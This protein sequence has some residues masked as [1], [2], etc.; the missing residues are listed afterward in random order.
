[1][2]K[3]DD[4]LDISQLKNQVKL[5]VMITTVFTIT[6]LIDLMDSL[7]NIN[8]YD[9]G[10]KDTDK[11]EI[12]LDKFYT[13]EKNVQLLDIF[14]MDKNIRYIILRVKNKSYFQSDFKF[15]YCGN[16]KEYL[17]IIFAKAINFLNYKSYGDTSYIYNNIINNFAMELSKNNSIKVLEELRSAVNYISNEIEEVKDDTF[18]FCIEEFKYRLIAKLSIIKFEFESNNKIYYYYL[19]R[20]EIGL[21]TLHLII[22]IAINS[23]FN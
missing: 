7:E 5:A 18:E 15:R 2:N 3:V 16:L 1:M 11:V 13:N 6:D 12:L 20:T 21:S 8:I 10:N 22:E 9:L 19:K 4:F 23:K 14:L 17:Y